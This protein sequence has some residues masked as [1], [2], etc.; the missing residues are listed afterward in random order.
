[1]ADR[2]AFLYSHQTNPTKGSPKW[3]LCWFIG[4]C[5]RWLWSTASTAIWRIMCHATGNTSSTNFVLTLRSPWQPVRMLYLDHLNDRRSSLSS[6]PNHS[7]SL[8]QHCSNIMKTDRRCRRTRSS[9]PPPPQ[10]PPTN[11]CPT[12][13]PQ[14]TQGELAWEVDICQAIYIDW[15]KSSLYCVFDQG[16]VSK[17][18]RR[19]DFSTFASEISYCHD[20]YSGIYLAPL[21]V[22][23]IVFSPP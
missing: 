9:T 5:P 15:L 3:W 12:F 19:S 22:I 13:S 21:M 17:G 2:F 6:Y 4:L 14:S 10:R 11:L 7:W 20:H 1:M 23:V 18:W 8:N 16:R